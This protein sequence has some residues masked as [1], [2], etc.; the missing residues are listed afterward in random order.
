M[1]QKADILKTGAEILAPAMTAHGF[2][3]S[4]GGQGHSSGGDFAFGWWTRRNRR[5]EMR[6][7]FSLGLVAYHLGG[8]AVGHE[9]YIWAVTGKKHLAQYPGTSDDILAAF[10]HLHADIK[11]YCGAFLA[12]SDEELKAIF[13][14]VRELENR[15]RR[16]SPLARLEIE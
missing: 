11:Q 2:A 7:R 12:G 16:M 6:V 10:K 15:W 4:L 14:K 9:W 1:Q 13:S 8:D 3:F 5:L